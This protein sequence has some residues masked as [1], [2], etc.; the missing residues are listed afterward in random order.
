MN[1][2]L[3]STVVT[4]WQFS[5]LSP[6]KMATL[7]SFP[8]KPLLHIISSLLSNWDVKIPVQ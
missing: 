3:V 2:I 4:K 8:I 5:S 7:I 1:L 6:I